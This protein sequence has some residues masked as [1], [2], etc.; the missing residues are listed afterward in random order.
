MNRIIKKIVV[1]LICG[2]LA[3]LN[4]CADY[5]D[6]S[7]EV[8]DNLTTEQVF[9]NP[10]YTR[11]WHRNIFNCITEYSMTGSGATTGFTGIWCVFSGE[12]TSGAGT[13]TSPLR[14][15]TS[16]WNADTAPCH[17]WTTLYRCI[18]QGMIFLERAKPLGGL[19]DAQQLSEEQLNRMKD[20]VKYFIAYSYF[21]LFELYGAVP[22]VDEL[23]DPESENLDYERA[24]VDEVIARVDG[25]LREVIESDA[26]PE[27]VIKD[28]AVEG[29]GRY[30]LNE[31]V[32]PTKIAAMA[33]RAKLWVYAA[34]PLFNGGYQ[35]ALAVVNKD[36][37]HLYPSYDAEKWKTAKTHLEALL[38]KGEQLGHKLYYAYDPK[39]PT[40][41]DPNLSVYNLFQIY[42]D[43]L[44]WATYNTGYNTAG[45]YMEPSSTPR[46]IYNGW[47]NICIS[48]NSVDAFFDVNGLCVTD[49]GSVYREDGFTDVVNV[50]NDKK[51]VD[52]KVFNMYAN[53]EPRFYAAV[54]YQGKSWHIQPT[55][56]P[57]Y[58]LGFAQGEPNDNSKA[59][60]PI[61]G[62]LFSK[63]KNRQLLNT[64]SYAKTWA[65]PAVLFRL[66]DFYLYY[67]EVCNEIDSKD[68]KII[69]YLDAVR[70]RAGIPGY[71]ELNATGKKNIIGDYELQAKAIRH[72][73]YVELLAEGQ[74]YFD[75]RRW[76]ICG[77]GEEADQS[78]L[79][80]L[81]MNGKSNVAIGE[82]GSYFTRVLVE[83]RAWTR[84]MYLY[85]I[86]LNEIQKSRLLVQNPLWE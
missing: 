7:K 48:Q 18:R 43:E 44:L 22:L 50:C 76:M 67:A 14:A 40:S 62:S 23:A 70:K 24:S 79:W 86:S 69:T 51:R 29:N 58:T 27:T 26:L 75:V 33:L 4:S 32:R 73:R 35:E 53:R 72:E 82:P 10:S 63:F 41:P 17:R 49:P 52:K 1:I 71:A 3:S 77:P 55:N 28:A 45:L 19:E 85:P 38:S 16:G 25:L 8:S 66:A 74:R 64:G 65:R 81:N 11:N 61:T 78:K 57:D 13:S 2:A 39:K 21:S 37:K 56:K 12:V 59:E 42:N 54:A 84:A 83:R 47:G 80:G 46:D 15:M 60:H 6:V 68:P 30:D 34:S 20:E 5:L 31:M 9:N 36:G